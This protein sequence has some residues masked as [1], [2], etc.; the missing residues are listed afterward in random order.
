MSGPA[1]NAQWYLARDGEQFGPISDAEMARFVELGHLKPNDLLWREGFPD[2]RPAMVVFPPHGHSLQPRPMPAPMPGH[3]P[4]PKPGDPRLAHG[5]VRRPRM[6]EEPLASPAPHD[7]AGYMGGYAEGGRR[8]SRA[9]ARIARLLL[10]VAVLAAA[11]GAAYV[12]RAPLLALIASLSDSS[13]LPI[14]DRRSLEL[15]PLAG[16]RAGSAE[17]VDAT[18]QST[19][20]WKVIKRE[21]LDWYNERIAEAVQMAQESKD[22]AVIGQLIARKLADLRKQHAAT[23]L[24]A[25]AERL[26]TVAVAYFENLRRLRSHDPEACSGLIRHGEA[27]PLIVA[28][29]QHGTEHTAYLQAQLTAIFEAI[30]EGRQLPRVHP[31]PTLEQGE[32]LEGELKKRGW[33]PDDFKMLA[34]G[35][36]QAP[37]EKVCQLVH[38]LFA[39]ELA[40]SDPDAQMR[41]LMNSLRPVLAAG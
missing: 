34:G 35:M 38:D 21:F 11:A 2:W 36:A 3:A 30:A 15:P 33:T 4:G 17:A 26:K 1:S 13:S 23:A 31:R 28:L 40:L 6:M 16:F 19:A 39:A 29:L 7:R 41:L 5:N 10:L 18:L 12:Y 14:A 22:D 27:E 25:T 37:A 8:P 9:L 32:L 20:L 24:S